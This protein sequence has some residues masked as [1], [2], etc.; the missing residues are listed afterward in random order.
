MKLVFA[1]LL[2]LHA[3]IHLMG[4]VKAFKFAEVSQLSMSISKAAGIV[5]LV[6]AVVLIVTSIAFLLNKEWWWMIGIFALLFSQGLIIFYWSDAKFGTLANIILLIGIVL[7]YSHWQFN[8][9][10]K[11]EVRHFFPLVRDRAGKITADQLADLPPMVEK[12][13]RKTNILGKSFIETACFVQSGEMR[14]SPEGKW[15]PFE[16]EQW[17]RTEDAGFIWLAHVKAP[18]G[19]TIAARDN[20][21]E[22]KG[23]MHIRLLSLIPIEHANGPEI[24]QGAMLRYLG[25]LVWYPTAALNDYIAWEE[26]NATTAK[27]RMRYGESTA[28]A[29]FFFN[30]QGEVIRVEADRYYHQKGGASLERWVIQLEGVKEFDGIR[31]PARA[32]IHWKLSEG[33][34]HWYKVEVED[35]QYNLQER[36]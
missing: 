8:A 1:I 19:M 17:T 13:L 26:I 31:V 2:F 11:N 5:W 10:V 23:N 24:D 15:T 3:L 20:Y 29:M 21:A 25:E 4:F 12:W 27:A 14:M 30:E 32:S 16:A 18:M 22:G 35:I 6:A 9:S 28:E 33:D 7:S 36:Q 34:Y